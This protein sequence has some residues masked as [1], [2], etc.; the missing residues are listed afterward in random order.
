M[1][2]T[3]IPVLSIQPIQCLLSSHG[4]AGAIDLPSC[5]PY[6]QRHPH[7]EQEHGN[8][9]VAEHR[10]RAQTILSALNKGLKEKITILYNLYLR[11]QKDGDDSV[12]QMPE[13]LQINQEQI[14]RQA[15]PS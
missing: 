6:R 5:L 12:L 13:R 14:S 2:F 8:K 3:S 9:I 15:I 4:T 11:E 7:E 10:F 1:N